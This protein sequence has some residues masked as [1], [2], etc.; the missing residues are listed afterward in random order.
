MQYFV[1]CERLCLPFR[2]SQPE[3]FIT[4]RKLEFTDEPS[5]FC[6]KYKNTNT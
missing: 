4:D 1:F 6:I 5:D 3:N 2:A